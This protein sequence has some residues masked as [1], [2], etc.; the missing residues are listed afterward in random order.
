MQGDTNA[1]MAVFNFLA[2]Y[3]RPPKISVH[4]LTKH[5]EAFRNIPVVI[6]HVGY[7]KRGNLFC[8]RGYG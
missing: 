4:G 2:P 3:K 1:G 5:W 6:R 8:S 7:A